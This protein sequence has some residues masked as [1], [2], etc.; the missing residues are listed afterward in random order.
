MHAGILG[1]RSAAGF[2]AVAI[3][4]A[5]LVAFIPAAAAAADFYA[6]KTI[7]YVV[8]GSPGGG[9]DIYAR[10]LARHLPRHI[11]GEPVIVVRNM[12]G[13]GSA[14]AGVYLYSV[15]P[16]DGTVIAALYPGALMGPV[17][18]DRSKVN[19]DP[20]KFQ[21]LASAE[22]GARI[23]A[24]FERS[25]AKTFDDAIQQ[26]VVFGASAPGGALHDYAFM[27]KKSTGAA[28]RIVVGYKATRDLTLDMERGEVDGMCGWDWSTA[29]TQ[30]PDWLRDKR[31]NLLVQVGLEPDP[32][33]TKLG[34]PTVW[35]FIKREQ[36]RK[37]V[38]LIV[39]QQVFA[40]PYVA[41]PETPDAQV[42]ILRAAF[43]ATF[44]DKQFLAD[45]EKARLD[46]SPTPGAKVQAL[47]NGIYSA[48]KATVDRAKDL[49]KP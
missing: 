31:V 2:A 5:A 8:G 27:L 36:D 12:P 15:A 33:L 47:I 25:K 44:K 17:L 11:P 34:V 35:N 7:S 41:P 10:T 19:Y 16:K 23:C 38:E 6:G 9:H 14:R 37:A 18:D 40:R 28:F 30:K 22:N 1:R 13:A 26:P 3:A 21:Y 4:A 46:I 48:P 39:T 29:K 42:R 43:E 49:I 32:E 24:T 45:A 20:T